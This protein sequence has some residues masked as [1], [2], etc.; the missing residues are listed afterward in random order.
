MGAPPLWRRYLRF[1]GPDVD[2]DVDEELA[3][4]LEMRA[5]DFEARGLSRADAV[6][7]AR[8][9]FGDAERVRGELRDHDRRRERARHRRESMSDILQDLRHGLRGLRRAPGF[10]LVAAL[11]LALGIGATT[12]I[13]SVV[14]AVLLRPLPYAHAGRSAMVWLDNRRGNNAEDIHSWPNFADLRAQT[15]AFDEIAG[16]ATG[17]FNLTQGC[18]DAACE[19]ER[20]PAARTT[21]NL[22]AVLGTRPLLGRVYRAEEE[23]EGRDA[24]VVI[25]HGLWS[26]QFGAD[27]TAVGRTV[28]LNGRERTIIGVLPRGFA[29]PT[30]DT[31]V[32]V[33]L[34]VAPRLREARGAYWLSA[35]GRLRPGV[36]LEGAR[37]DLGA[38]AARLERQ[39]PENRG[40]GVNLVALPDQLVGRSVRTALWVMLG[41]VT[42]VLLIGC[43]N[44][45]NLLLSR[46]A[47]RER[48]VGVR[49]ALGAGRGR[50]VRQLLT[51]SV[52]LAAIG[53]AA[54]VALAWGGLAALRALAPAD[55][56]RIGEVRIDGVVLLVTALVVIVT[57]VAFGLVPALRASRPDLFATL[58]EG[59]RGGTASRGG[60]Q[61]RRVLAGA[62]VALVVVLLTG[63]GLLIRSFLELQRVELGFRPDH[64]L[65][66]ELALPAA[67]YQQAPQRTAFYETL[68]ERVGALPG[69]RGAGA[70]SSIFLSNTPNS[71]TFTIAGRP[72][73]REQENVEVPLD[74]VTPD[75][76][77]VMGVPLVR[78]RAFTA[79]DRA[80]APPVVIINE[81]MARRFWPNEDPV[82]R[83]FKYGGPESEAPWMTIVGVVGDMRRTGYDAPVRYETFLPVAQDAPGRL[84]LVVRTAGPPLALVGAV[85]AAVRAIDPDQPVSGVASMDQ[86]LGA[87]VAE[88]RFSMAL[89]GT[90]AGLALVLGLVGVYGVTSYLVAQRTRELGLRIALGANP[91]QIV[92]GVVRQGMGV[93]AAG[94]GIGLVGALG[95]ARL[96]AGLLYGVGT[97]D[98]VT[99]AAV[100]VILAASTL[101][102]NYIPARRAAAADPLAALR[103]E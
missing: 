51:E 30:A 38:I 69:V 56:P 6:R 17:G 96:M 54:G 74:A 88:R 41:A 22:F 93:A 100:V 1:W 62:Q 31:D 5:R 52:L 57:G 71:T 7:A 66:M 61:L 23:A 8:Q 77:R 43:A 98:G 4:H 32:W 10:T 91:R 33:P 97:A 40:L 65:T 42:A 21:A 81:N 67:K 11:T 53:G 37:S 89:L 92:R 16:F 18:A 84:T 76:F 75:Y 27:P 3:F 99:L 101:L 82:G 60:H 70:I 94:L 73:T 68:V 12:A 78:G 20:V 34:V 49:L 63:A 9:R 79:A 47:A 64:L 35:V 83:R 87:M 13:F 44:V 36:T 80:D 28:R 46:A 48:E 26:R 85:R 19:P 29:F 90:F 50:L 95:A 15:R 55:L 45:A 72:R 2:A 86:T 39:F 103:A 59:G 25:G 24:V 14:H 102:A 58:R